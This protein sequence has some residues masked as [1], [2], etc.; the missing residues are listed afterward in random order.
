MPLTIEELP[1]S[2]QG[3]RVRKLWETAATAIP[4]TQTAEV[5]PAFG[6][7]FRIS[8]LEAVQGTLESAH[9]A[10]QVENAASRLFDPVT[11]FGVGLQAVCAI[12]SVISSLVETMQPIDYITYVMLSKKQDGYAEEELKEFILEFLHRPDAFT[13]AWYLGMDLGRAERARAITKDPD[14]FDDAVKRLKDK[15]MVEQRN[16]S[17]VFRSR[18]FIIGWNDI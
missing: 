17:L 14:W 11:W 13:F 9:T 12:R 10:E 2:P 3:A 4:Q 15:D 18:N 1:N 16:G 5:F 8:L 6:A 7:N